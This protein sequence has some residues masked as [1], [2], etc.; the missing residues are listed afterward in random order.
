[1]KKNYKSIENLLDYSKMTLEFIITDYCNLNCDYC[2]HASEKI[3]NKQTMSLEDI[4]YFST[5]VKENEF[6]QIKIAGGEPTLHPQFKELCNELKLL[7]PRRRFYMST[8][9]CL[10]KKYQTEINVF[11]DIQLSNYPGLNDTEYFDLLRNKEKFPN[12]IFK[13][14]E[15]DIELMDTSIARNLKMRKPYKYCSRHH[16]PSIKKVE[17]KRI[18]KCCEIFANAVRQNIN[19]NE[20]S[21]E[22]NENWREELLKIDINKY[23]RTCYVAVDRFRRSKLL[24]KQIKYSFNELKGIFNKSRVREIGILNLLKLSFQVLRDF[25]NF[26]YYITFVNPMEWKFRKL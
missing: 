21:V 4:R 18:A 26:V 1:M 16:P 20:I 13:K 25:F 15:K 24:L 6:F 10:L 9:G 14:K 5:L 7:F 17:N 3:T 12:V 23:C 22:F 11:D 2:A 8:N 19:L